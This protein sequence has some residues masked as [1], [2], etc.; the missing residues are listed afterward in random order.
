MGS[1]KCRTS[2]AIALDRAI[3]HAATVMSRAVLGIGVTTNRTTNPSALVPGVPLRGAP[4]LAL[5]HPNGGQQWA[6]VE[7]YSLLS[8]RKRSGYLYS[9]ALA[10]YSPLSA[11]PTTSSFWLGNNVAVCPDLATLMLPVD[12]NV[13]AP[14][15][16]SSALASAR[17]P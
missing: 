10:K 3:G 7:M 6:A 5:T 17:S 15:L 1:V 4:A 13:P 8:L 9:S 16:Y 2:R 12:A 11:P 14:G